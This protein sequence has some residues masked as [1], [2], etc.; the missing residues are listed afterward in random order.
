MGDTRQRST[1]ADQDH[2][3]KYQVAAG[4]VA[5]AGWHGAA[6]RHAAA[7]GVEDLGWGGGEKSLQEPLRTSSWPRAQGSG[8][9]VREPRTPTTANWGRAGWMLGLLTHWLSQDCLSARQYLDTG[10]LHTGGLR[11]WGEGGMEKR[12]GRKNQKR[13]T[14]NTAHR[15]THARVCA[16][17]LTHIH[18]ITHSLPVHTHTFTHTDTHTPHT[19]SCTYTHSH[20]TYAHSFFSPGNVRMFEIPDGLYKY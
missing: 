11:L 13:V 16:H 9:R 2:E 8:R 14:P 1:Q 4:R 18:L 20:T 15:H 3:G 17:T 10:C 12:K 19:C 5:G 6:P 7:V